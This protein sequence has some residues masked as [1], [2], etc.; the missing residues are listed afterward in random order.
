MS[1]VATP[2][3]MQPTDAGLIARL[4]A[5][6]QKF[7]A[8]W[9]AQSERMTALL[10]QVTDLTTE[11]DA[12]L[13]KTDT[14]AAAKRVDELSAELRG[15][16]HR[17][18]FDGLALKAGANPDALEDLW[19][20]SEI[21][22]AADQP[23]PAALQAVIDQQKTARGWAFQTEAP[24]ADPNAPP[25]P[26]PAVGSGQGKGTVAGAQFSE[27]QLQDPKFVMLNYEKI[28]QAASDRIARGEI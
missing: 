25:P 9:L 21:T 27:E 23:D 13:S 24:P 19:K 10:K 22:P 15:I 28:T 7:K 1:E 14:S 16:R 4:G 11:R 2:P 18:A 8:A 5:Q 17:Q 3:V 12:L 6:K 20:L 26:K